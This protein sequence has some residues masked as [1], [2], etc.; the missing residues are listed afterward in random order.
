MDIFFSSFF[1]F[2]S[3]LTFGID[4]AFSWKKDIDWSPLSC[5]PSTNEHDE[6]T[7]TAA[8]ACIKQIFI[9]GK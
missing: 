3:F 8:A 1:I 4:D 7:T 9:V 2:S 6:M 5:L